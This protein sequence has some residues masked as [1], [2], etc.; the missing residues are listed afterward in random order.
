MALGAEQIHI[1]ARDLLGDPLAFFR[2]I[3]KHRVS[4]TF[5]PNFFLDFLIKAMVADE[6][7]IANTKL[8]LSCLKRICSGGEANVVLT[9]SNLLK[10]LSSFQARESIIRPGYGLTESCAAVTYDAF[11]V[12]V[13]LS[14][15]QE[16][17]SV[18]KAIAGARL[19]VM[20]DTGRAANVG[21]IG[22]LELS[23][24]VIFSH[25]YNDP[26]ATEN[27]FRD[28]G[29]F[30]T[31]D[32]AYVDA[33]GRLH[34]AGRSKEVIVINGV[35]YFP[36]EIEMAVEAGQIP[37]NRPSY[38]VVFSYRPGGGQTEGFC[39]CYQ[40]L[41]AE[42][43][44]EAR[45]KTADSISKAAITVTG[46]RP[47]RIIPLSERQLCKSTLG[48]LSRKKIQANFEQGLYIKE[49]A[50]NTH[51]IKGYRAKHMKVARTVT[52]QKILEVLCNLLDLDPEE[53]GVEEGI[54][55]LGITSLSLFPFEARLRCAFAL[56]PSFTLIALLNNPIVRGIACAID[57]FK[58]PRRYDPVVPLQLQGDKTPLW[59]VHPASGNVLAFLPLANCLP[60][61]PVY[62]FRTRGLDVGETPFS[63]INETAETYY[64]SIKRIQS[65]RPYLIAGYSLGTTIAFEIAKLLGA[66]GDEVA[67]LGAIDSPPHISPLV[68]SIDWPVGAAMV[69][70]FLDLIPEERVEAI[71]DSLRGSPHEG[72]VKFLLYEANSSQRNA[73]N[74]DQCQ[75]LSI[76][77]VTNAFSEAAKCYEPYGRVSKVDVFYST[78]LRSVSKGREEW[79]DK[80][81]Q[82]WS[83][84]SECEIGLHECEGE[85]ASMLNST[86]VKSFC[87]KLQSVLDERKM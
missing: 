37:G 56:D 8:D 70:Y 36:Q 72:I 87:T 7:K 58:S 68:R 17:A 73:L 80:H 50:E 2:V 67:F 26:M 81:L 71:A 14:E 55:N 29:W 60:D 28:G 77:N 23:G 41:F 63:T 27:A 54:F 44:D 83:N 45:W 74:L 53:V 65:T 34:I 82:I 40:P 9:C 6:G 39:I 76:A 22:D 25:Y 18:G 1:E 30:V 52:E 35:K 79:L 10:H 5:A 21:E 4:Q 24:P 69:A 85:H 61:R 64:Q 62:A 66:H 48:K 31:G 33:Y 75:L 3:D 59:L 32:R 12:P 13:A 46:M 49:E 84:F 16:I 43:D 19:R 20:T 15:D 57:N 11:Q 42:D 51:R 38:T 86:Y 47:Y 78:P